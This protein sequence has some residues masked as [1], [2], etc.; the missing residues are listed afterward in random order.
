MMNYKSKRLSDFFGLELVTLPFSIFP[1]IILL[2]TGENVFFF[3]LFAQSFV[4]LNF[5]TAHVYYYDTICF[6][7][8]QVILE[9]ILNKSEIVETQWI[10]GIIEGRWGYSI[11]YKIGEGPIKYA[12]F[13]YN[14]RDDLLEHFNE[15]IEANKMK[16][17]KKSESY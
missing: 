5:L 9:N 3:L 2:A 1:F 8:S 17:E 10:Q 15:I 7:E 12:S 4:A 14:K 16:R 11:S 6:T 13:Y